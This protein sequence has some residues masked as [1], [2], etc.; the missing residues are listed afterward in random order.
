MSP[1]APSDHEMRMVTDAAAASALQHFLALETIAIASHDSD[2][3]G[4]LPKHWWEC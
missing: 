1:W 2:F 3:V 4:V